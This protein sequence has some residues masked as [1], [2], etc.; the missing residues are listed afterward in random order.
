MIELHLFKRNYF[1]NRLFKV[2]CF[3]AFTSLAAATPLTAADQTW[4]GTGGVAQ[5]FSDPLNWSPGDPLAEGDNLSIGESAEGLY[6]IAT[7]TTQYPATI[8]NLT[9]GGATDGYLRMDS[10]TMSVAGILRVGS[11]AGSTLAI[12][13]GTY[14]QT[15]SDQY[16]G[17][18]GTT[19]TL[20]LSGS[21]TVMNFVNG[22]ANIYAGFTSAGT[23]GTVSI[24]NGAT[25]NTNSNLW[26]SKGQE[27]VLEMIDGHLNCGAWLILGDNRD[28]GIGV[29]NAVIDGASTINM[30]STVLDNGNVGIGVWKNGI[31]GAKGTMTLKG[32]SVLTNNTG[33]GLFVG[34]GGVGE[35]T[36][37]GNALVNENQSG[38]GGNGRFVIGAASGSYGIGQVSTGTLT[39]GDG[40]DNPT[41]TIK[42]TSAGVIGDADSNVTVN[43]NS[44]T[45]NGNSTAY[46][47]FGYDNALVNWNQNGGLTNF[48]NGSSPLIGCGTGSTVN[49]NLNAGTFATP[50][51]RTDS[52]D[53]YA[54]VNVN[55]NGGLL[56]SNGND[57]RYDRPYMYQRTSGRINLNVNAGGA[58]IDT[59]GYSDTVPYAF[60]HDYAAPSTDDG[61]LTKQGAGA[62]TLTAQSTYNGPT[63][64]ED[65]T[66]KMNI[67]RQEAWTTANATGNR[68]DGPYSLGR[69]FAVNMPI[70]VTQ[71][72]VFDSGG[73]GLAASHTVH[74]TNLYTGED[75]SVTFSPT[76]SGM[77]QNGFRFLPLTT[78][79]ALD[80]GNY[81]I[82]VG[83]LGGSD[84][85]AENIS[86]YDQGSLNEI[87]INSYYWDYAT[88]TE[89]MPTQPATGNDTAVSFLFYNPSGLV[90]G[91]L[92]P[93]TTSV[94]LGGAAGSTPTLDL[95]G[96]SQQVASLAD[97]AEAVVY[98]TVMNSATNVPVVLTLNT[99][100]GTTIYSGSIV[101]NIS[102]VKKGVSVQNL[103]GTLTYI[104][105]TAVEAGT[106]N[107]SNLNTPTGSVTVYDGA[108]LTAASIVADTLT[109][110]GIAPPSMSAVPEPSA[111]VLLVL[112]G[113]GAILTVW[114]RK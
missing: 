80:A 12:N 46:I 29:G 74:L 20:A 89:S 22:G 66:L 31:E 69:E 114:R 77:Y 61:G 92:L 48:P 42:S 107:V 103:L 39:L 34:L 27:G 9:V 99:T 56:K 28:S 35:L 38:G 32:A 76:A 7:E 10:G 21:S 87:T 4:V 30:T 36:L 64:V 75:T 49:L 62:L 65:G 47:G 33:N 71:L 96:T 55:F 86:A 110:G 97:V 23:K 1:M 63:V 105:N 85:F 84:I 93:V 8:G 16:I 90:T 109:I 102:L 79:L 108:T 81:M 17:V 73:D 83:S 2:L 40:T 100:S 91:N 104:G 13:G 113:M 43:I 88:S 94:S 111:I 6:P 41:F 18:D 25:F 26:I 37:L 112:A 11:A 50:A 82:W 72:G 101:G 14:Y 59:N 54:T 53:P 51:I 58:I 68:V 95:Q 45:F 52:T 78:P 19:G 3:M 70:Q 106:L 5:V 15:G 57:L 24:T 44:G 60:A 67:A 98:G